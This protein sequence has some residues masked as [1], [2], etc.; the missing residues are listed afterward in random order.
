MSTPTRQRLDRDRVLDAAVA[1]ADATTLEATSMRR[2]AETL[3]VTPMALYKHVADREELIDGMV[4][5]VVAEIEARIADDAGSAASAPPADWR[6]AVRGRILTARAVILQHAWAQEA[7][8][9]RTR[10]SVAVLSYMD[11]LIGILRAG[12]LP[13]DLVHNAMHAL[14]TR[15]W[16]F[17]REVFPTPQLPA[18]PAE[19]A[20]TLAEFA[21]VYPNIVHMAD[22]VSHAGGCDDE[23]EFAFALDLLLDGFARHR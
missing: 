15:M 13:I 14:S 17:T 21:R 19:R 8:V 5:V 20:A 16:G 11:A 7:I 22:A 18:D 3:G 12:G 23:A 4:D 2:L 10:S 9:T 1:L 6:A